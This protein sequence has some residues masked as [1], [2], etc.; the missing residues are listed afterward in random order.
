MKNLLTIF[1]CCLA[2]LAVGCSDN[3]VEPP[4]P[5]A[6]ITPT[7]QVQQLW[8]RSISASPANLHLGVVVASD[9][10]NVYTVSHDGN[11][12]AFGLKDGAK[13]WDKSLDL[14]FSGGPAVG[15]GLVVVAAS[16][17]TV[18]ALK[19]ATGEESWQVSVNDEVVSAPAIGSG[20]IVV[21]TT[22]DHVIALSED[23][24]KLLWNI[25]R[26]PPS[27]ALRG[28]SSPVIDGDTVYVGLNTGR[29]LALKLA[30][31]TQRWDAAVS[32]PTGSDELSQLDDLDGVVA[33]DAGN[34]YAVTYHGKVASIASATG[35]IVWSR[36]MSSY[37]GV[38]DN[39]N[40]IYISDMHGDIW[41][42]NKDN[43]VP[44]WSQ[45]ALRARDLTLPVPY[46]DTVVVGDLQGYV[47][48]VSASD[49]T[50]VA[51]LQLDSDPIQAP[52][53]VAGGVLVVMSTGGDLA[54]YRI[55][56]PAA[57]H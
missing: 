56:P 24:G 57:K 9:G 32:R 15:D 42:L 21:H 29:L 54:A 5:L 46:G 52:P 27:L 55:V 28:S 41:K 2:L 38:S 33:A 6:K 30:D 48:F 50:F 26:E 17:G 37:T 8:S 19:A 16:N 35:Q 23:T 36:D 4:A 51:R 7:V 45:P 14:P 12:Y 3:N 11:V 22:D 13:V 40:Y 18:V 39:G 34:L 53:I 31:G 1:G 49:G 43:G 44:V 47:H 20:T 25:S 10:K